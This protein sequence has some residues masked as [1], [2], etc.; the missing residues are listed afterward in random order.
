MMKLE[1][2]MTR[3]LIASLASSAA[4][5]LMT[6][7]FVPA[8]SAQTVPCPAIQLEAGIA[9]NGFALGVD[10]FPPDN[11]VI[12]DFLDKN[13][14]VVRQLSAGKG[15]LLV[16]SRFE[17]ADAEAQQCRLTKTY[18]LR[19]NGSVESI[20]CCTDKGEQMRTATGHNVLI[21]FPN[22]VPAGPSTNL[23]VGRLVF[24][25]DETTGFTTLQSFNRTV[26]D[27]CAIMQ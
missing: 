16:F 13:G 3:T 27:I 20:K 8:S 4:A 18:S 19:S 25:F 15:N 17:V 22:D 23:Y 24:L 6:L 7:G 9:C 14:N 12:R 21:L 10:V 1:G 26:T 11:R 5:T 2:I